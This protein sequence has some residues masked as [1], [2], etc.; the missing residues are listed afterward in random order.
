MVV[1]V[2]GGV[3]GGERSGEVERQGNGLSLRQG[4]ESERAR[5]GRGR[6][7]AGARGEL[8]SLRGLGEGGGAASR[9]K[10]RWCADGSYREGEGGTGGVP[11]D[12][13]ELAEREALPILPVVRLHEAH[14]APAR[15]CRNH[16]EHG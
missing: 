6:A 8:Y 10:A 13:E 9:G 11:G 5:V 2:V 12:H 1:V 3:A 16:I 7:A 14:V 15:C 4:R